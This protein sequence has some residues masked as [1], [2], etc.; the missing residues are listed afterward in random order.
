MGLNITVIGGGNIGTLMA[1]DLSMKAKVSIYSPQVDKW[2]DKIIVYND[3][4]TVQKISSQI[5]VTDNLREAICGAQ[6][7]FITLPA[8]MFMDIASKIEDYVSID[9]IICAV[10]GSGGVEFAFKRL[11]DKGVTVIGLQ[12]V[13]CIARLKEYGHSVYALGRKR[14]IEIASI[15]SKMA[16]NL[17]SEI[18]ELFSMPCIALDNYL[19]LT[20][21]PSN[22]ILHTSRLYSLF[23][24]YEEEKLYSRVPL[25]YEEWNDESS[26]ILIKMDDELQKLCNVIPIELGGVVSLKKY[27]AS[28]SEKAMTDKIR[29]IKAFKGILSPM[30]EVPNHFYKPDISSRYFVSD[31]DFGLKIICDISDTFHVKVKTMKQAYNWYEKVANSD[32][33]IFR[34]KMSRQEFLDLYK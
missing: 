25:F 14:Q 18:S 28:F 24:N 9:Q 13:H 22:P 5:F 23:K 1:A 8:F 12:R 34:L 3:D 20:L 32:R 21:T 10:P 27:Y 30:K 31:F 17:R 29:S 7:I 4:D 11:I 33:A 26:K 15:P 6:Y 16:E 2:T 19:C